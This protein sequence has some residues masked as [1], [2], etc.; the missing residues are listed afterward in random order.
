MT[1]YV[2]FRAID[3]GELALDSPITMTKH[4]AAEPPSKM[5]F[6]PGSVMTLDNALKMMLIK[7]ANDIAMAVGE[8]VGGTEEAFV[9]RM[10]AEALRLGMTG[11]HW[12]NPNGLHAPEQYTTARDLALLVSAIRNEY[13]QYAPYFAIQ[14]LKAGKK[15]LMSYNVLVGRYDGADGMKTGFVCASGFNMIGSATRDGKTL[16][17]V[18]L[19]ES[20]AL[21][22]A[23]VAAALLDR[24]FAANGGQTLTVYTLP[25]YG[26]INAPAIDMRQEI[27]EKKPAEGQSEAAAD[28]PKSPVKSPWLEKIPNAKLVKVGLGGATGPVPKAWQ[29]Q[30]GAGYAD[31]PIPTPRPEY[32]ATKASAQGDTSAAN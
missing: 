16:M 17:A 7:S 23:D 22:R 18:V 15:T 30:N 19:G 5:G 11:T 12:V 2:T 9:G 21:V 8:N 28:D 24:G 29:E 1:A 27:C 6:K 13:P 4:A 25:A 31:V 32:P 10:N 26:L 14:G 20:S 3:A